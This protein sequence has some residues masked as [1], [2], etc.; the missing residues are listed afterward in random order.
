MKNLKTSEKITIWMKRNGHTQQYIAE[1]IGMTRQTFI[2]RMRD[3][4]FKIGELMTLR[5][6]GF[7]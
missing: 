3:N 5:T 2:L 6:L 7:D 1:K 4:S